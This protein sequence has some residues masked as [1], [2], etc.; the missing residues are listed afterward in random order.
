MGASESPTVTAS[1]SPTATATGSPTA[2][3][4][5]GDDQALAVMKHI[6]EDMEPLFESS[7]K[8]PMRSLELILKFDAYA[9]DVKDYVEANYPGGP[10]A[11]DDHDDNLPNGLPSLEEYLGTILPTL[12][13]EFTDHN[14]NSIEQTLAAMHSDWEK[15]VQAAIDQAVADL[16]AGMSDLTAGV[17]FKIFPQIADAASFEAKLALEAKNYAG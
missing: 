2:A 8:L 16:V 13:N 4:D 15:T 5:S 14:N 7:L 12:E 6:V 10:L 1:E 17:D 3:Q 9:C 11:M